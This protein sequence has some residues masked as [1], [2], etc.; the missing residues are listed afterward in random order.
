MELSQESQQK[1]ARCWLCEVSG[2]WKGRKHVFSPRLQDSFLW[3]KE[4][5]LWDISDLSKGSYERHILSRRQLQLCASE[6][7]PQ[8][9]P[10][11][12]APHFTPCV[13]SILNSTVEIQ[14]TRHCPGATL[15][16]LPPLPP[17][18]GGHRTPGWFSQQ[19]TAPVGCPSST[20]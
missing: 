3:V 20:H 4:R 17:V 8:N 15:R 10:V 5:G 9:K 13:Y 16:F 12:W 1:R 2:G 6:N 7:L 14:W 18:T 19:H 11:R